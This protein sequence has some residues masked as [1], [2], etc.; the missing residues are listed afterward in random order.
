M[1][2][3]YLIS[4]SGG[5]DSTA[6]VHV[7]MNQLLK[8]GNLQDLHGI[9]VFDGGWD[10]PQIKDH[11][12]KI[13]I[14]VELFMN[15][16]KVMNDFGNPHKVIWYDVSPP[17]PFEYIM[18]ETPVKN[19]ETNKI[20]KHG[21]GWPGGKNFRWCTQYKISAI[22]K[23][24]TKAK[25]FFREYY[26][27]DM[28]E[29]F[30]IVHVIGIAADEAH[31]ATTEH[32]NIYPLIEEGINEADALSMCKQLGYDFGGL[33]DHFSRIGCYCCPYQSMK[34]LRALRLHFPELYKD[35][36][37]MDIKQRSPFKGFK[38]LLDIEFG[39]KKEKKAL[40]HRIDKLVDVKAQSE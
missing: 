39:F 15:A 33:Y 36:L 37:R 29:T 11:I 35:M 6:L 2:K 10:F 24:A 38:K 26:T 31:R 7:F 21:R 12:E 18:C 16:H 32:G 40:Q 34:E 8:S 20:Y 3:K 9:V 28:R 23:A 1:R 25:R 13:K 17:K 27:E 5:K 4:L 30:E 22:K 14:N 19:R